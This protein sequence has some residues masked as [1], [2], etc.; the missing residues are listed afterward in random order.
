MVIRI[1]LSPE[2][3]RLLIAEAQKLGLQLEEYVHRLLEQ[4]MPAGLPTFKEEE[5]GTLADLFA[6][7]V[8]VVDS[9]GSEHLSRDC[10]E[11][12]T[13]YL[14]QKKRKGHL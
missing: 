12:F 1:E 13:E 9:G 8:G 6:G 14:L 3:E 11:K 2:K 5:E 7:R 4:S 10:G